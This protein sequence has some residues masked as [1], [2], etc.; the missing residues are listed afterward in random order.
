MRLQSLGDGNAWVFVY[1]TG[2]SSSA[3]SH[4]FRLRFYL[5]FSADSLLA[6]NLVSWVKAAWDLG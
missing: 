3:A 2:T 5:E 4:I 1:G 6:V